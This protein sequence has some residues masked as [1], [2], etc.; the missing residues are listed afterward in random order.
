MR[1]TE[2]GLNPLW[3]PYTLTYNDFITV[4]RLHRSLF[5][6]NFVCIQVF[7]YVR[8]TFPL[9]TDIMVLRFLISPRPQ[10]RENGQMALIGLLAGNVTEHVVMYNVFLLFQLHDLFLQ[11]STHIT[12]II[13]KY[14]LHWIYNIE[15]TIRVASDMLNVTYIS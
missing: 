10:M 9:V 2:N 11:V 12:L 8:F 7:V 6:F 4:C 15:M 5:L 13:G 3:R 1:L 14:Q